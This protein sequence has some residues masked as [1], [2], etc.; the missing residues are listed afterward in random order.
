MSA[1]SHGNYCLTVYKAQG[2]V[3]WHEKKKHTSGNCTLA[4]TLALEMWRNQPKC[5]LITQKDRPAKGLGQKVS[6]HCI[7]VCFESATFPDS[8]SSVLGFMMSANDLN[9]CTLLLSAFRIYFKLR[10]GGKHPLPLEQS[11]KN[12]SLFTRETLPVFVT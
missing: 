6:K 3:T 7:S 11:V 1:W 9:R 10:R 2:S 4:F 5:Q 8:T 12:I